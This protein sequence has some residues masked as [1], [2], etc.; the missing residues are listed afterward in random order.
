MMVLVPIKSFYTDFK[1]HAK[2]RVSFTYDTRR[3]GINIGIFRTRYGGVLKVSS[4]GCCVKVKGGPTFAIAAKGPTLVSIAGGVTIT[5]TADYEYCWP[6]EKETWTG[7]I[8]GTGWIGLRV[9]LNVLV[10][11]A[12]AEG[13]AYASYSYDF[14]QGTDKFGVGGYVRAV[15][16]YGLIWKNRRQ[17]KYTFGAPDVNF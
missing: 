4:D 13:G 12:F 10:V 16:E 5:G 9:G 1:K 2:H 15:F 6:T 8:G 3:P 17:Y 11:N 14:G 7:S